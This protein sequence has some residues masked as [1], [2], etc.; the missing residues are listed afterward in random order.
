[1]TLS[2]KE[3]KM[4]NIL[5]RPILTASIIIR[6]FLLRLIKPEPTVI[7]LHFRTQKP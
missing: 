1:M 5:E 4:L 6:G 7:S 3:M 2:M